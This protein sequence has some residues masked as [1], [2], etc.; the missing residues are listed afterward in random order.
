MSATGSGT[1]RVPYRVETGRLVLRCWAPE[2]AASLRAQLDAS[3]EHLRPWIPFM[4]DEPRTL[5]ATAAWLREHR[6]S[7]D[8]DWG[9]RYAVFDRSERSLLG[10]NML[11]KRV[12][13]HALEI[14][15]WIAV[16][17]TG[18]GYAREASAALVRVA[19]ELLEVRRI[20]IHCA[21]GNRPSAAIPE[22]L[23]FTHEATLRDRVVDTEGG[24]HDL[25]IWTLFAADFPGSP[26]ATAPIAAFDALGETLL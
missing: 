8:L 5:A 6:A 7:F 3:D 23:G 20:E 16:N 4:A 1:H 12:G 2:D 21:P 17:A 11:L 24:H 13:A 26:A 10:E 25:M 22:R 9:Y 14:G 19:F 15:Y 18:H